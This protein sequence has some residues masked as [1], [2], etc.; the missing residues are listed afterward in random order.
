MEASYAARHLIACEY[1]DVGSSVQRSFVT[2][3]AM[4]E[5]QKLR[6]TILSFLELCIC[7]IFSNCVDLLSRSMKH[8]YLRL[9]KISIL[10]KF[11]AIV[12]GICGYQMRSP[13]SRFELLN[14]SIRCRWPYHRALPRQLFVTQCT[15]RTNR[16]C[17]NKADSFPAAYQE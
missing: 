1:L 9:Q 13:I 12:N 6:V 15:L 17:V 5:L 8:A 4:V 2:F 10:I 16:V 7:F 14:Q 11:N 3:L